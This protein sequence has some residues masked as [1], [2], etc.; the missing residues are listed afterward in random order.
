MTPEGRIKNEIL[1]YLHSHNIFCW[2]ND[3]VGIFDPNKRVFRRRN[4][5][6]HINGVS[7]ILGIYNNKSLAIEVKSKTGRLS[8]QQ[9]DFLEKFEA[10]GGIA[11]MARSVQDVIDN[12]ELE[13]KV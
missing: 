3:S 4:S 8:P 13:N 11:F 5:I 12:L 9:K 7:D 10:N 1:S 6:Y 2:P